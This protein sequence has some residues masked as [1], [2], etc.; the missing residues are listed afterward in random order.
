MMSNIIKKLI[1]VFVLIFLTACSEKIKCPR[2]I[3]CDNKTTYCHLPNHKLLNN[4]WNIVGPYRTFY[5]G[6]SN[7]QNSVD[8]WYLMGTIFVDCHKKLFFDTKENKKV[9]I[10]GHIQKKWNEEYVY[11]KIFLFQEMNIIYKQIKIILFEKDLSRFICRYESADYDDY[12]QLEP[13]QPV[14]KFIGDDWIKENPSFDR[15]YYSTWGKSEILGKIFN[16]LEGRYDMKCTSG[17]PD[18]CMAIK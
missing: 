1:T 2:V 10:S 9:A 6:T 14:K 7:K 15:S 18:K 3:V 11:N 12:I 4:E 17:N 16:T 13:T 5:F 8:K